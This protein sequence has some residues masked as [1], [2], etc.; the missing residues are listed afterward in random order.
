MT[1]RL[2]R[3]ALCGCRHKRFMACRLRTCVLER[4]HEQH[5]CNDPNCICHD[6]AAW[7]LERVT[8]RGV[9][10]YRRVQWLEVPR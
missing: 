1:K 2:G 4:G 7:G 8:I 3:H 9:V 5:I 10:Q 6:D